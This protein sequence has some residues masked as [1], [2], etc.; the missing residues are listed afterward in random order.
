MNKKKMILFFSIVILFTTGCNDEK[1]NGKKSSE[2][3]MSE[4]EVSTT[5]EESDKPQKIDISNLIGDWSSSTNQIK[6][7]L[8]NDDQQQIE[9]ESQYMLGGEMFLADYDQQNNIYTFENKEEFISFQVL[10]E[11]T[12]LIWYG[13]TKE[14]TTGVSA[15]IEYSKNNNL[16]PQQ[17]Q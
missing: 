8:K 6:I 5:F 7:V 14:E 17:N 16:S 4:L 13:T 11:S 10:N 15:P 12:A 1:I 3:S 9:V 2:H